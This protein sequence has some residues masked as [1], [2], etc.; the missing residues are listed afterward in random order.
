MENPHLLLP[1]LL[2]RAMHHSRVAAT[3][4]TPKKKQIG[5]ALPD[6]EHFVQSFVS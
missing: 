5:V 3:V 4:T 1:A 6:S 2:S